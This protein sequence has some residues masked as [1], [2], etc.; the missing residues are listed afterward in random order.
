MRAAE[1]LQFLLEQ[2]RQ[3]NNEMRMQYERQLKQMRGGVERQKRDL[4][5]TLLQQVEFIIVKYRKLATEAVELAKQ[6]R[7]KTQAERVKARELAERACKI[8]ERDLKDKTKARLSPRPRQGAARPRARWRWL[9]SSARASEVC[10]FQKALEEYRSLAREAH[11]AAKAE[12][13]ELQ[14]KW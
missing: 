4:K 13:E 1:E 2:E 14:A 5:Q 6:E 8:F 10:L 11:K 12:R 9:A 3:R 7:K